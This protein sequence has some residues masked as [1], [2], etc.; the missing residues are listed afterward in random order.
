M[1]LLLVAL[2]LVACAVYGVCWGIAHLTYAAFAAAR[3]AMHRSHP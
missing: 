2:A 1:G 3:D